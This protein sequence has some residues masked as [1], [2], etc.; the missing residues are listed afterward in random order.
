[1][2]YMACEATEAIKFEW[3]LLVPIKIQVK[4]L[5]V[6]CQTSGKHAK[7][8]SESSKY[9]NAAACFVFLTAES[10]FS[11]QPNLLILH[12]PRL[13][14]EVSHKRISLG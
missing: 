2:S 4:L 6:E 11:R 8:A 12:F 13:K 7:R 10:P 3:K 9:D 1:M 5:V 14:A